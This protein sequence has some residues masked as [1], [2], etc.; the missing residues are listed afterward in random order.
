MTGNKN[1][2]DNLRTAAMRL[3]RQRSVQRES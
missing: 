2:A 3:Q 1:V